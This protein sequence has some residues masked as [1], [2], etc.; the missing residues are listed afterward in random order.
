MAPSSQELG[1][2]ENPARFTLAL[3]DQNIHLPQFG[4]HVFRLMPL[5]SHLSVLIW[6]KSHT[7]GRTTSVVH[8]R[9]WWIEV[10]DG[11]GLGVVGSAS[12]IGA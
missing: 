2:P 11:W 1:P 5:R 12:Q 8:R 3:R 7:S 6:L 10:R 9:V 4:D